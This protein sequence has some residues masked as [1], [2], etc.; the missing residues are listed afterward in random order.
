MQDSVFP[1]PAQHH[2]ARGS[3]DAAQPAKALTYRLHGAFVAQGTPLSEAGDGA[4]D[5]PGVH[6]G[7]I[8][9]AYLCEE[10]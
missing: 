7:K 5:K 9:F 8:L 4:V 2:A 1:N 3:A 10:D 6:L